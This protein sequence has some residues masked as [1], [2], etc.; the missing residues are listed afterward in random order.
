MFGAGRPMGPGGR[1]AWRRSLQPGSQP[2]QARGSSRPRALRGIGAPSYRTP[3]G[4]G[5]KGGGG[6]SRSPP[7]A[8]GAQPLRCPRQGATC[9][10][11]RITMPMSRSGDKASGGG[12]GADHPPTVGGPAPQ[13][14]DAAA[15]LLAPRSSL[16]APRSSLL[17]PRPSP[18]ALLARAHEE[19]APLGTP[20]PPLLHLR[21]EHRQPGSSG[22]LKVDHPTHRVGVGGP[23]GPVLPGHLH[24]GQ[25]E[26]LPAILL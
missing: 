7:A 21:L 15:P 18:F 11:C 10:R 24:H 2:H 13:R 8:T 6:A 1:T 5:A 23:V 3:E 4:D 25:P 16:L 17:A 19:G 22:A 20:S 26:R 14:A 9:P 12:F